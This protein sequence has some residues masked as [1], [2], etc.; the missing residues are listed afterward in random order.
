MTRQLAYYRVE[1]GSV[2]RIQDT[3]R[4]VLGV[5]DAWYEG[6]ALVVVMVGTVNPGKIG[7]A[8]N[9]AAFDEIG[10]DLLATNTF[11]F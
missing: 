2:F 6:P 4:A 5:I 11:Q 10:I 3:A 9:D 1:Y 7:R 8:V